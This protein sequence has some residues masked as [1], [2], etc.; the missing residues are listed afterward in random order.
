MSDYHSIL[1]VS[2]NASEEEIKRQYKKRALETHPDRNNGNSEEFLK[3]Q[4]AY[5][6]LTGKRTNKNVP[7]SGFNPFD[8]G[9]F[10]GFDINDIINSFTGGARGPSNAHARGIRRPPERDSEVG[11]ELNLNVQQIKQGQHF[12]FEYKKSKCCDKCAGIGGKEKI[13]SC[14]G[15]GMIQQ[16]QS[17]GNN[18]FV[19]TYPCPTCQGAGESIKDPCSSCNGLGFVVYSDKLRFEIKEK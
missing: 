4:E 2:P 5:E 10:S 8:M 12:E 18:R 3:V 14:N 13:K 7:P 17:S 15:T 16:I 6:V 1:G 9:G 11:I 19:T